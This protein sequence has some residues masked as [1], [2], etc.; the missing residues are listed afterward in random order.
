MTNYDLTKLSLAM[1]AFFLLISAATRDPG[2]IAGSALATILSY[3]YESA[4]EE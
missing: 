3:T 4:I 1:N 2:H